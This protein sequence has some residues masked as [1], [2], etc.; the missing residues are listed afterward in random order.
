VS[1]DRTP[2]PPVHPSRMPVVLGGLREK[3]GLAGTAPTTALD[4]SPQAR[5]GLLMARTRP[6]AQ[7][8]AGTVPHAEVQRRRAANRRARKA[9]RITRAAR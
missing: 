9:R 3:L 8:Y 4:L 6:E 5:M 1:V 7:T 2:P